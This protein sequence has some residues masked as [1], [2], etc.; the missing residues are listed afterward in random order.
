LKSIWSVGC[1]L[2]IAF[3]LRLHNLAGDS[4]WEDEIFTATQSVLPLDELLRWTAG[5]IHPPGY[6]VLVGR[7]ANWL[8]WADL[9]RSALS[10]WLWRFPSVFIGILAVALTYRL[11]ADILGRRVGFSAALLL[12][13][14]PIAVQYSQEARMHGLFLL[15]VAASTWTL[16]RALARPT[17]WRWWLGY[18]LATGISLYTVYLAFV[19]LAAQAGWMLIHRIL[20]AGPQVF[21]ATAR[22]S[23][24]R[25]QVIIKWCAAVVLAFV[26]YLPWW[27]T[28]LD[29]AIRRLASS[30]QEVAP[31]VPVAFLSKGLNS[32]GPAGGWSA[33]LFLVLWAVGLANV[34]TRGR[35]DLALFGGWWLALPLALPFIF[36]DPRAWHV[37]YVFLLPVYLMFVAQGGMTLGAGSLGLAA[38]LKAR[39]VL[40]RVASARWRAGRYNSLVFLLGLTLVSAFFLPGYYR[41]AKPDWRGVAE[42]LEL[43]TIP[44][45]VIVTGPLFDVGRYLDYYYDGPAE[46]MP[47]AALVASLPDRLPSMRSSGGRVWAVTRFRPAPVAAV[48][49]LQFA[50]LTVSEPLVAIYEADVLTA[51]MI[52]LM[53]QAVAAA[54]AWAAEMSAGG[55]LDPEPLVA[56]AAAYLFLGDVYRTE[57]RLPE[58]IGAYEAMVADYPGSAAGYVTLAEAYEAAGEPEA[59][60]RAYR[61]AVALHPP[62]QGGAAEAAA[63]L[64]D[65]DRWVDAAAAYRALVR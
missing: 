37:R 26:L 61:Q 48:N 13:A 56:Q 4:L 62:W 46:L 54:P 30:G 6:Y 53:Q 32:L 18:G 34:A 44:A 45:D 19:V 10:D 43:H 60:V 3:F 64:A 41:R 55:V 50:G 57:G 21:H 9:P 47:P 22:I 11:G 8:G 12:A 42:Y 16:A 52:S 39:T 2:L 14:S 17:A 20:R 36:R 1:I 27:P 38:R 28:L 29:I 40:T 63:R 58:A 24:D 7:L 23:N 65:D 5:D 25:L 31:G 35:P 59:A 51:A 15:G 49:H 33:W